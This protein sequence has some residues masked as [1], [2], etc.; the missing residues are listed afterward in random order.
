MS[1]GDRP[2]LS[3]SFLTEEPEGE[4]TVS[5]A[6]GGGLDRDPWN[7]VSWLDYFVTGLTTRAVGLLVTGSGS[8]LGLGE[9][10]ALIKVPVERRAGFG[11]YPVS[12]FCL[13]VGVTV[14]IIM[15][16]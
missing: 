12:I 8:G 9:S 2:H 15:L 3:S 4:H 11:L 10:S 1:P 6:E 16:S 7:W 5:V 13:R 14:V